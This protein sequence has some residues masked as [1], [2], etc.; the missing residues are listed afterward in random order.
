MTHDE[1]KGL[2]PVLALDALPPEDEVKL[3]AH[4]KVCREC[5]QLLSEHRETAGMLAFAADRRQAS[6]GLKDRI[7]SQAARTP[8]L[9]ATPARVPGRIPAN[10]PW[11][12]QWAG[13]AAA[14]LLALVAGGMGFLMIDGRTDRLSEQQAV[15]ARQRQVLNLVSSPDAI[16]LSMA[17]TDASSG[18]EGKAFI[19]DKE[20][21]AAVVV[22]G[23]S[24]PGDDVYTLWLIAEGDP[25]PVA[26]FVPEDGLALL[27]VNSPVGSEMTLAVTRE[28]NPGNSTPQGPVILAASRA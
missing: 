3:V 7:L 24:P 14:C 16:V 9:H 18:G 21:A 28:P 23:L 20:G 19:S 2:V 10:R 11:R 26:D 13:L 17:P 4:L 15:I 25:K 6:P 5:S 1:L 12:W 22:S 8:Q 27:P